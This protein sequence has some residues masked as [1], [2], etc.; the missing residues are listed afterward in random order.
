MEMDKITQKIF[1]RVA[2]GKK[3]LVVEADTEQDNRP[4]Y[5]SSNL[6]TRIALPTVQFPL[7]LTIPRELFDLNLPEATKINL[8]LAEQ[9]KLEATYKQL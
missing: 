7:D 9:R 1:V 6:N 5:S 4:I 3:G 8:E 2:L